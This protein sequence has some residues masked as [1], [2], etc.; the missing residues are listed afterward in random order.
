MKARATIERIS[1]PLR[2]EFLQAA[3]ISG[4]VLH[5]IDILLPAALASLFVGPLNA[6]QFSDL[7]PLLSGNPAR[8]GEVAEAVYLWA[9][10][11]F[12]GDTERRRFNLFLNDDENTTLLTQVLDDASS[13][14]RGTLQCE[15]VIAGC[16]LHE[17][18]NRFCGCSPACPNRQPLS[19]S[20]ET[21]RGNCWAR[22]RLLLNRKKRLL[23]MKH[24]NNPKITGMWPGRI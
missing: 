6:G 3:S 1:Q 21:L 24:Q 19:G 15:L 10:G 7:L 5:R 2:G 8:A 17:L 14:Q 4:T 18:D 20:W 11:Q 12:A 16:A 13:R 9:A 23:R 22:M